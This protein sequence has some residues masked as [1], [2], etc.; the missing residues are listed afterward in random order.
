MTN[1][2]GQEEELLQL[3]KVYEHA[4]RTK[5]ERKRSPSKS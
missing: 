3:Q 1:A 5:E 4:Q 2:D